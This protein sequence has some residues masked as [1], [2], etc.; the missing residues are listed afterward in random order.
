MRRAA[1][2]ALLFSGFVTAAEALTV[3]DVIDLTRAGLGEDVLLA[4]IEVDRGI[5]AIDPATIKTLKEAGVSE[6]VI[7]ALVRSGRDRVVPEPSPVPYPVDPVSAPE[8]QVVVIDHDRDHDRD[9]DQPRVEQVMV[10]VPIYVTIPGA[11][12]TRI[13]RR[14]TGDT[15]TIDSTFVPFQSGQPLTRPQQPVQPQ[16]PVYWGHGGKL[17]PDAWGQPRPGEREQPKESGKDAGKDSG[18]KDKP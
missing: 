8:P 4:L 18:R 17:R 11:G 5:Y 2:L 7:V 16:A 6:R 15:T 1:V 14:Q 12:R 9:H 10:P 3:R 13:H